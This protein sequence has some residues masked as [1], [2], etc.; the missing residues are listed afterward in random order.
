MEED[1]FRNNFE[2]FDNPDSLRDKNNRQPDLI[3]EDIDDSYEES[4]HNP[5]ERNHTD[6]KKGREFSDIEEYEDVLSDLPPL[7]TQ[8]CIFLEP[9][10][11]MEAA[12]RY[13]KLTLNEEYELV[14]YLYQDLLQLT[15]RVKLML[16]KNLVAY[17]RIELISK[18]M[19][20]F[21]D[22]SQ[23]VKKKSN[24]A[25]FITQKEIIEKSKVIE[26]IRTFFLEIL[27]RM[28]DI[29]DMIHFTFLVTKYERLIDDK[30]IPLISKIINSIEKQF[31][32]GIIITNAE[33]KFRVIENLSDKYMAD[34]NSIQKLISVLHKLILIE[35]PKNFI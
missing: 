7:Q 1:S 16:I 12:F 3:N 23:G 11:I 17:K 26:T 8:E 19:D 22:F 27:Y 35:G 13:Q 14:R 10:C 9:E 2:L 4:K 32:N 33:Y 21:K 25:S 30:S 24:Y 34:L 28:I 15:P 20:N 31:T 29:D 5:G 18:F 6:Y